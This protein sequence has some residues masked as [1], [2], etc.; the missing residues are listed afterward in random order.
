MAPRVPGDGLRSRA[1]LLGAWS[2]QHRSQPGGEVETLIKRGLSV[3]GAV[4]V[5]AFK[6]REDMDVEM[7][8]IT[9][10]ASG[11]VVLAGG[12]AVAI[13]GVL[14]RDRDPAREAVD[15]ESSWV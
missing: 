15:V 2:L 1:R 14:E 10:V 9:L 13:A 4:E 11:L 6:P 5:V 3:R 8:E 12:R 7:P